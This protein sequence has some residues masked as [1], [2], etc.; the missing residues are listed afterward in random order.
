MDYVVSRQGTKSPPPKI[1]RHLRAKSEENRPAFIFD[2]TSSK[3]SQNFLGGLL[4]PYLETTQSIFQKDPTQKSS[5]L[6]FQ[7]QHTHWWSNPLKKSGWNFFFIGNPNGEMCKGSS[8]TSLCGHCLPH[9]P[10]VRSSLAKHCHACRAPVGL[11]LSPSYP[12]LQRHPSSGAQIFHHASCCCQV[13][14]VTQNNNV[15]LCHCNWLIISI[16]CN[17]SACWMGSDF[18]CYHKALD[19]RYSS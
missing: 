2:F 8:Y 11:Q 3:V 14:N 17:S 5:V 18:E 15:L 1:L 10:P 6:H 9:V 16:Q 13:T 19:P 12:G 4:V 7:S